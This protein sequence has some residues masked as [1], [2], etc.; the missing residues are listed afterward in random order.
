MCL[1]TSVPF[2]DT[3]PLRPFATLSLFIALLPS[4]PALS[5]A[6]TRCAIE[7][8]MTTTIHQPTHKRL[9]QLIR[10]LRYLRQH[11]HDSTIPTE[12]MFRMS[13]LLLK[14]KARVLDAQAKL[15]PPV[16]L[17]RYF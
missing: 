2:L 1:E 16:K 6:G 7:A 5:Q 8:G 10:L 15:A 14:V 9:D 12:K 17:P 3:T 11:L 4:R 13:S